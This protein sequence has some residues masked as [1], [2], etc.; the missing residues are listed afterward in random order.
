MLL[1]TMLLVL[2]LCR[3]QVNSLPVI[4][5]TTSGQVLGT[6]DNPLP[7]SVQVEKYF[8]IPYAK[9]PVGDL[10]FEDP[11]LMSPWEPEV[12]ETL[13]LHPACPQIDEDMLYI[14]EHRVDFNHTDEDCLYLNVFVPILTNA[15]RIPVTFDANSNN[16]IPNGTTYGQNDGEPLAVL[17]F[18]HGGSNVVGTAN[19]FDGDVLA[20]TGGIVVVTINYRLAALGFLGTGHPDFPGNYGILDQIAAL[21]WVQNNIASFNGDPTK[22]TVMGHSQG[23]FDV[24]VLLVSPLAKGLFRTAICQSGPPTSALA[25][26]RSD[27]DSVHEVL[28]LGMIFGCQNLTLA[29]VKNCLKKTDVIPLLKSY[30]IY[31]YNQFP[32]IVGDKVLPKTPEE[33]MKTAELNAQTLLIGTTRDEAAKWSNDRGGYDFLYGILQLLHVVP[34]AIHFK[35]L[36]AFEY[37]DMSYANNATTNIRIGSMTYGD[38]AFDAPTIE[39]LQI[40]S[41]RS[42]TLYQYRW[43]WRS[44]LYPDPEV[45]GVHHGVDLFYL[46]GSPLTGHALYNYTEQDKRMSHLMMKQWSHFV[47]FSSFELNQTDWPNPPALD[48]LPYNINTK[49][50]TRFFYNNGTPAMAQGFNLKPRQT[51]FWTSIIPDLYDQINRTLAVWNSNP[52]NPTDLFDIEGLKEQKDLFLILFLIFMVLSCFLLFLMLFICVLYCTSKNSSKYSVK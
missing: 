36:V 37:T 10:R 29:G 6:I 5:N 42:L 2:P 23:S 7:A 34:T 52:D 11:V 33:L 16:S 40:L 43:E 38:A 13:N 49:A 47:K 32:A 22:V 46:F 35:D 51:K 50:Y 15:T 19:M 9:P 30:P 3:A 25:H 14:A 8:G 12:L 21:R 31:D 41:N 17:V 28:S 4:R 1:L 44:D 18:I 27:H 24:G 20:A 48:E 39:T 45:T 26:R